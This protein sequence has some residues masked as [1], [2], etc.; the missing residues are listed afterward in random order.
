MT[1]PGAAAM[2]SV[3][4]LPP[5]VGDVFRQWCTDARDDVASLLLSM[6]EAATDEIAQL[7]R[8]R[9]SLR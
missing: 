6:D 4:N 3:V 5:G 7:V 1:P 2:P 8:E 9:T